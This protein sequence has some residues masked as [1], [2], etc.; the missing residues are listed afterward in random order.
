[1]GKAWDQINTIN[2]DHKSFSDVR[3]SYRLFF[4][5]NNTYKTVRLLGIE[6]RSGTR[7]ACLPLYHH[8]C[9][10]HFDLLCETKGSH[11]LEKFDLELNHS[12]CSLPGFYLFDAPFIGWISLD[13][14]RFIW[15]LRWIHCRKMRNMGSMV[16]ERCIC[17]DNFHCF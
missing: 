8:H 2:W 16:I 3:N 1:M 17:K 11:K 13:I 10:L 15:S 14:W 9:T 5:T 6:R 12:H 7:K 4:S